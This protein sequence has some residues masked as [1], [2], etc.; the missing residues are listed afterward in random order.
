MQDGSSKGYSLARACLSAAD[1]ISALQDGRDASRLDL[2]WCFDRH[3]A[4]CFAQEGSQAK[5]V[6]FAHREKLFVSVM[7]RLQA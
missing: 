4:Q 1:A 7:F 2:S 3:C 6:E 5:S